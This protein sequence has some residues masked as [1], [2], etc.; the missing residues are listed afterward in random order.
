MDD[1]RDLTLVGHPYAGCELSGVP[2]ARSSPIAHALCLDAFVPTQAQGLAGFAP[3]V[4]AEW[5]QRVASNQLAPPPPAASWSERRGLEAS[6]PIDRARP[7]LTLRAARGFVETAPANPM[8]K[9]LR[10][11]HLQRTHNPNPGFQVTAVATRQGTRF[12]CTQVDGYHDSVLTNPQRLAGAPL[13]LAQPDPP[14]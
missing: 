12:D 14:P 10:R 6:G 2:A 1:L 7:R 5:K 4:R 8:T 11:S 13:A 9:D 3:P